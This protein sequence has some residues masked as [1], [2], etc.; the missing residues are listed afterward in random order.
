MKSLQDSLL[1]WFYGL[2]FQERYLIFLILGFIIGSI[3]G[4]GWIYVLN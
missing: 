4:F 2:E 3:G 1:I